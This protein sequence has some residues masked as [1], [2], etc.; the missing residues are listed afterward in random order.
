[1]R[2]LDSGFDVVDAAL[3][4][5]QP[6]WNARNAN[7]KGPMLASKKFF[8]V[9]SHN[10]FFEIN[11]FAETDIRGPGFSARLCSRSGNGKSFAELV[12]TTTNGRGAAGTLAERSGSPLS[13][14]VAPKIFR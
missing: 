2:V 9:I 3:N 14:W 10:Q 8:G 13:K 11:I 4:V 5:P 6:G 7:Q 1:M 12:G